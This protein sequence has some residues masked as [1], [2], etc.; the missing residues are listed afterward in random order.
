MDERTYFKAFN[1]LMDDFIT[2]LMNIVPESKRLPIQRDLF[3]GYCKANYKSPAQGFMSA[4]INYLE[5]IILRDESF[6][7]SDSK[8]EILT[9]LQIEVH[10]PTF[11]DNTKT[12]IWNYII[13]LIAIGSKVVPL[14][15]EV[16]EQI[17]YL[18]G[19]LNN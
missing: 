6:F 14:S 18:I 8:P 17:N 19:T 10:L 15:E 7:L 3:N 4:V 5:P 13:N 2:E 11:S 12:C 16:Q 1:K 9:K